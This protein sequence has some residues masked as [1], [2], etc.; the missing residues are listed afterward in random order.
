[1]TVRVAPREIV[2]Y[3]ARAVRVD[4]CDAGVARAVGEAVAHGEVHIGGAINAFLAVDRRSLSEVVQVSLRAAVIETLPQPAE[5]A[6]EPPVPLALLAR[7][8]DDAA[9]RGCPIVATCAPATPPTAG[10][11]ALVTR[12]TTGDRSEAVTYADPDRAGRA[13]SDGVAVA[14]PDWAE[15]VARSKEYLVD[16]DL[17]DAQVD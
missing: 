13:L 8:I 5:V 10:A 7:Q 9:E 4:G 16:E 12:L 11:G 14:A 17:L 3:V 2:D 15:L 6:F 1:M